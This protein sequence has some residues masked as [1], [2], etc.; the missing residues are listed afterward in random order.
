MSG[1]ANTKADMAFLKSRFNKTW[2]QAKNLL[3]LNIG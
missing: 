2:L 1:F 3:V